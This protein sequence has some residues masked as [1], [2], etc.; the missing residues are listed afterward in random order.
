[1][2]RIRSPDRIGRAF[3][4][5]REACDSLPASIER[6]VV[7]HGQELHFDIIWGH[8]SVSWTIDGTERVT[9]GHQPPMI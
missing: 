7:L 8:S 6:N 2:Q 4:D 1:M 9:N 5:G 3:L